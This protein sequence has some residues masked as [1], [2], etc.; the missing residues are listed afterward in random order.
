MTKKNGDAKSQRKDN[1]GELIPN[2][3]PWYVLLVN[4]VL[5][6]GLIKKRDAFV[7]VLGALALIALEIALVMQNADVL[8]FING[9]IGNGSDSDSIK[10][11]LLRGHRQFQ[12]Q[13]AGENW[14]GYLSF[15][16]VNGNIEASLKMDRV[17]KTK[18]AGRKEFKKMK[19]VEPGIV[20]AD[21]D[22]ISIK[23]MRVKNWVYG[24]DNQELVIGEH[25]STMEFDLDRTPAFEGTVAYEQDGGKKAEGNIAIVYHKWVP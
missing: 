8:K 9:N 18:Y 1:V 6:R 22:K 14:L 13:W 12:W 20:E 15:D 24:P 16:E 17:F 3:A 21:G 7:F 10:A 25:F 4:T 11:L 23:R 2:N 5:K 19:S